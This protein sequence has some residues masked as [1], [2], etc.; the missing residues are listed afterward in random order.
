MISTLSK[1]GRTQGSGPKK[2][3]FTLIEL[4]VVIA[5]IALLAAILFPVF[6]RARENARRSTCQSNLK[7]IGLGITQYVQ[8][9]DERMVP[10]NQSNSNSIPFQTLIYPYTKNAQIFRCLSNTVPTTGTRW[11]NGSNSATE[12]G[13]IPVSYKANGGAD[14]RAWYSESWCTGTY[15][16]PLDASTKRCWRP[17]NAGS[18]Y[19]PS[20]TGAPNMSFFTDSAKIILVFENVGIDAN[21]VPIST[22]YADS[23]QTSAMNMGMTSHLGTTNFLFAD[24]HVKAMKPSATIAD[25]NMWSPDPSTTAPAALR[26]ALLTADNFVNQ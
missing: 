14:S 2:Q 17:M 4:L 13:R 12:G 20:G 22:D 3:A 25:G 19:A 26:S 8:D 21:N 11:V 1:M 16:T 10:C 5:I 18:V 6:G 9:Y 23:T 24:G 15:T 7:Q